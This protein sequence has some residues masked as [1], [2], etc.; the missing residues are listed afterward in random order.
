M[1]TK[2]SK[3]PNILEEFKKANVSKELIQKQNTV[4][5]A[6][7]IL[8]EYIENSNYFT[9]PT[10]MLAKIEPIAFKKPTQLNIIKK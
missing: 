2:M 5:N 1:G 10:M 8:D 4:E 9:H 6:V 7:K 3:S